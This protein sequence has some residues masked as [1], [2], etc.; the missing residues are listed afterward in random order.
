MIITN[1]I[2]CNSCQDIIESLTVHDF[3][4]CKCGL[5]AVDGGK[6]YL[7]RV[8]NNSADYTDLSETSEEPKKSFKDKFQRFLC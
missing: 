2:Q 5:I 3:K 1:K 8:Y 4:W 7:R 6:E